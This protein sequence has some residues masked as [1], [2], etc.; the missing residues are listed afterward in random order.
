MACIYCR[1]TVTRSDPSELLRPPELEQLVAHLVAR[2]GLSKVRLTG[3]EPTTRKDLRP[4]IE[5][6]ANL[7]TLRELTLTTNG[8]TLARSAPAL[9]AAGL[10]RVNVS[11][12]S[13]DRERFAELTGVDGLARVLAGITAAQHA[14]LLPV[15]L[16]TVVMRGYNDRELGALLR[17]ALTEACELRFI[18]LMPMGP[19][20]P[21]FAEWYVS[22]AEM[23][24]RL[25]GVVVAWEALPYDGAA[26]RR[27]RV[28]LATGERGT[29]G[30]VTP[31]SAHFCATCARIRIAGD[32]TFYPCL[33]GPPAGSVR[34]ALRPQFDATRLD[35]V[36]ARGLGGKAP[37]HP[38]TGTVQMTDIGG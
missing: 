6:L 14:G 35:Q 37:V 16:N 20:A 31:M 28:E 7:G 13:L 4:I 23:R 32:G 38:P 8:L 9:R 10:H 22:E 33:M 36:L 26:A 29:V 30:F 27:Y 12:D 11:I 18:E 1:A 2:H 15:K 5:R 25:T 17:F 34:P 19:V 3:G 21:R 24:Q